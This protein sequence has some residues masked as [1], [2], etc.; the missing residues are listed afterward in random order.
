MDTTIKT[1]NTFN[2]TQQQTFIGHTDAVKTLTLLSNDY[3]ASGSEDNTILI[4]NI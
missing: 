3:I 4:W 2:W 1:W